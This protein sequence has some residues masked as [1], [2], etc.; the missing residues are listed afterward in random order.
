MIFRGVINYFLIIFKD[1][2]N[3]MEFIFGFGIVNEV[4][5]LRLDRL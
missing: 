2:F 4:K 5:Y 3:E 1:L